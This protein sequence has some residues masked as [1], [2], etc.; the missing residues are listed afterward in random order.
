MSG[1]LLA[2]LPG[3]R[4][5]ASCQQ[6]QRNIPHSKQVEVAARHALTSA[7]C[8]L[9]PLLLLAAA[10]ILIVIDSILKAQRADRKLQ[11]LC[12]YASLCNATSAAPSASVSTITIT[13]TTSSSVC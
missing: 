9:L 13:S 8:I 3:S 11:R 4:A 5:A 6:M 10:I 12:C 2:A 1:W 7:S